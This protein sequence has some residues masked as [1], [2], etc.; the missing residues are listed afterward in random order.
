[1]PPSLFVTRLAAPALELR[2]RGQQVRLLAW[3]NERYLVTPHGGLMGRTPTEAY[4][5]GERRAPVAESMLREALT[6]RARRRMLGD[7]TVSIAG[8]EFELDQGYLAG[9]NVTVARSLL[10]PTT[11]PWVEHE[12]QRLALRPVD[13]K[14]NGKAKR[15]R[16]PTSTKGIDSVPFDPAEAVLDRFVG[17]APRHAAEKGAAL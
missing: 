8:S 10:D 5:D 4:A 7:G 6:V 9:H 17:R 11:L 15:T 13:P 1:M 14:A 2:A 16:R 12:D 3:L